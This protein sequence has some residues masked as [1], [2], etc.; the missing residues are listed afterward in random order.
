MENIN[1]PENKIAHLEWE[2]NYLTGLQ[3]K[4][5]SRGDI[6]TSQLYYSRILK[7]SEQITEI[8]KQFNQKDL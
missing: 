8:K 3:N 6:K 5:F 1:S 4:A 2:I 7:I